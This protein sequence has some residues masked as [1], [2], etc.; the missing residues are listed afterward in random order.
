MGDR[1]PRGA[2]S[3]SGRGGRVPAEG[4]RARRRWWC[5]P[6][7]GVDDGR[8]GQREE[9]RPDRGLEGRPVAERPAGRARAALE[10]GVA[11]EHAAVVLG[12]QADRA[13]RVPGRVQHRQA[14]ARRPRCCWPSARSTSHSRS[15]WVSSHSGRSSG[16]SRIGAPV[17]SRSCRRHP[18]VVVVGVGAHDRL[19]PPLPDDREDRLDVVG[20]VD[21]HAL[22]VVADHPH[23]VV[24]VE[25]LAVEG[26]GAAGDGV[27]DAARRA[28]GAQCSR[29]R[30]TTERSTS[31]WCIFSNAASTSSSPISSDTNASR[32]SRPCW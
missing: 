14:G 5:R 18:D 11:G 24:D 4:R 7:A 23:V 20:G 31:P 8:V 9:S 17:R 32:S 16:C 13:G 2:R 29:H 19:D 6:V 21:D 27:V 26:E 10:E 3:S 30:I 28:G 15:G 1:H 22:R 12:Q 25:G